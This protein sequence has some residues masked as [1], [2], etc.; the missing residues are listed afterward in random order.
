M[1]LKDSTF[2]D[3]ES[4]TAASYES[5]SKLPMEAALHVYE[6]DG[7]GVGSG[8]A[9]RT[10]SSPKANSPPLSA[11]SPTPIEEENKEENK[12]N[13]EEGASLVQ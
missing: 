13:K 6:K 8:G 10:L 2:L 7:D 12:E 11:P 3:S 1:G 9:H 4:K 5:D